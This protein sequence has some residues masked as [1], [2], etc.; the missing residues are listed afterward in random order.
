MIHWLVAVGFA[1]TVSAAFVVAQDEK[2]IE[3]KKEVPPVLLQ[4]MRNDS[5]HEHLHLDP[6]VREAIHAKL[7]EIDGPW[8]RSRL[9]EE[10]ERQ[11]EVGKLTETLR[12][13]LKENLTASQFKR[14]GQLELQASLTE[15]DK[16]RI[17]KMTR[18][19][20]LATYGQPFDFASVQRTFPRAPELIV[21]SGS[22]P[23]A[24]ENWIN[25]KPKSLE[26][27]RGN[28]VAVHFYAF[29]CINCVRNLP[30][31]KA[32]HDELADKG[33]VVIG[34]QT[35]ETSREREIAAV[36]NAAKESAMDY[37]VL[38]DPHADNWKAWGNT[39]WPTVYLIDKD[40]YIRAWWQGELNWEGA[41]GEQTMRE[42]IMKLL[43]E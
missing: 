8:W 9:L 17:E 36:K 13:T 28:V 32:W 34:I 39:M 6:A 38:M 21:G 25:G 29:Q 35:P 7:D 23:A 15:D 41:K 11:V 12:A 19:D 2:A 31:Y 1:V 42:N 14:V 27:L 30:H 16:P 4:M 24:N 3:K 18:Q 43:A 5:I 40:G 33:L 26:G 20:V 22:D 37:S 10:K